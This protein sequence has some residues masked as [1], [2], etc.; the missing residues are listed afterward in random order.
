MTDAFPESA[1]FIFTLGVVVGIAA[2]T[3]LWQTYH[4]WRD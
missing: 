3:L 4:G 2:A 1:R